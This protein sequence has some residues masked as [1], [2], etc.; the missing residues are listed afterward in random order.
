MS[1][2]NKLRVFEIIWKDLAFNSSSK[3]LIILKKRVRYKLLKLLR[4]TIVTIINSNKKTSNNST[5]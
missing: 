2:A 5:S 3:T 4:A 1:F